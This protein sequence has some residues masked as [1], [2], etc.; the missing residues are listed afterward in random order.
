[1]QGKLKC[2][3]C[4]HVHKQITQY[5]DLED[6][7]CILILV[8]KGRMG[9]TFPHSFS[10]L[11]IRL[12]FDSSK[13][14]G[15]G[16]PIFLS[17]LIQELGRMCRYSALKSDNHSNVPYALVGRQLFKKLKE[18]LKRSP[19]ISAINISPDRYM[20]KASGAIHESVPEGRKKTH[21]TLASI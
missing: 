7:A 5:E 15:K 21:Q 10:C 16:S 17:S 9:D 3:N 8:D 13:E 20:V 2:V 12:S 1:M 4:Q 14:F 6:L 18:S 19:A 11:D